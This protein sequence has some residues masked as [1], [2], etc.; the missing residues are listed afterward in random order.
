MPVALQLVTAFMLDNG[1]IRHSALGS[2]SKQPER[3]MVK[4]KSNPSPT[5]TP[6]LCTTMGARTRRKRRKRSPPG[7]ILTAPSEGQQTQRASVRPESTILNSHRGNAS[8]PKNADSSI[9]CAHT[10][11]ST[12]GKTLLLSTTCVRSGMLEANAT[13]GGNVALLV[14]I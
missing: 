2:S 4:P 5:T 12:S 7:R 8:S 13:P 1:L 6:R 14:R 11:E 10:L 9:T 3:V